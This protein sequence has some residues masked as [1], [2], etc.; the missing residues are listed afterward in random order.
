VVS[1]I[2]ALT[3]P[4]AHRISL[5]S[6]SHKASALYLLGWLILVVNFTEGLNSVFM[7]IL[8]AMAFIRESD[9]LIRTVYLHGWG[10]WMI[11]LAWTFTTLASGFFFAFF[12]VSNYIRIGWDGHPISWALEAFALA[13]AFVFGSFEPFVAEHILRL[14][15][16]VKRLGND[17]RLSKA[18][19]ISVATTSTGR[20]VL[21]QNWY[22]DQSGQSGIAF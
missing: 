5:A 12:S 13:A 21:M 2:A 22:G 4:N 10:H 19:P 15:E 20:D 8:S 16:V 17:E 9:L 6:V 11:I 18:V 14:R 3:L 1:I 7:V